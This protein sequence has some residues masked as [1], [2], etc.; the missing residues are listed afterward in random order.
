MKHRY[1]STH[2]IIFSLP[3]TYVR[4]CELIFHM[5][6]VTENLKLSY[7]IQYIWT[8]REK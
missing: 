8:G 6:I 3:Y 2:H 7:M 4:C 1:L 5:K